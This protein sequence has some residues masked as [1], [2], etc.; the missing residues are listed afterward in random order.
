MG[1][2]STGIFGIGAVIFIAS[3]IY[4]GWK[5]SQ[6][7]ERIQKQVNELDINISKEIDFFNKIAC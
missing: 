7:K 2:I 1:S 6:F 5:W 3:E 4:G